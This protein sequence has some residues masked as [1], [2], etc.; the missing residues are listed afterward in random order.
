MLAGR[1]PEDLSG[2]YLC[3]LADFE[4]MG[5][6]WLNSLLCAFTYHIE[7]QYICNRR[8]LS[9]RDSILSIYDYVK[10]ITILSPN[11][12]VHISHNRDFVS[13]LSNYSRPGVPFVSWN[14]PIISFSCRVKANRYNLLRG[15]Y[16]NR[17]LR[18][19]LYRDKVGLCPYT[20]KLEI[21]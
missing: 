10:Q 18:Q 12:Q 5:F 2:R 13:R 15:D 17:D 6:I 16:S 21:A 1:L 9:E 7:I 4:G 20:V 14:H 8:T 19:L 11:C 3:N